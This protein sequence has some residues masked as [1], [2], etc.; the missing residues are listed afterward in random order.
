MVTR[1][2]SKK[3]QPLC[4][5]MEK[6]WHS[7]QQR[8]HFLE[9]EA[10][11]MV[12]V[13]RKNFE[14]TSRSSKRMQSKKNIR[15]RCILTKITA[16]LP[17][18]QKRRKFPSSTQTKLYVRPPFPT[19]KSWIPARQPS[20]HRKLYNCPPLPPP[21]KSSIP[22]SHTVLYTEWNTQ[23]SNRSTQTKFYTHAT[24]ST[25]HTKCQSQRPK[26]N[27][28][29]ARHVILHVILQSCI[30]PRQYLLHPYR[31]CIPTTNP[32]TQRVVHPAPPLPPTKQSLN[33][34]KT[35]MS[36]QKFKVATMLQMV[37][38]MKCNKEQLIR[39]FMVKP[40][41]TIEKPRF[42]LVQLRQTPK[43][44]NKFFLP[45]Q[46]KRYRRREPRS[47]SGDQPA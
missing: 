34:E 37:E 35:C 38:T 46:F 2:K 41:H 24:L 10:K 19:H 42:F 23:T 39:P 9:M 26:Q 45:A 15:S 18:Q 36:S 5:L 29:P 47:A 1:K 14:K 25:V 27:C 28:I 3:E 22:T 12:A 4:P 6:P 44:G 16:W 21:I 40:W 32:S 17:P 7:V 33:E 8:R 20:I 13:G 30:P 11:N 43:R 31:N